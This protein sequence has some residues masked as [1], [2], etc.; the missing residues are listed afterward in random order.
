MINSERT[1]G[2][3]YDDDGA[4]LIAI[5]GTLLLVAVIAAGIYLNSQL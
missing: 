1:H 4:G 5:I 2:L 3:D